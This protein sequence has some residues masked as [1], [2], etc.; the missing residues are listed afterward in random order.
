MS[1]TN[2]E[3]TPISKGTLIMIGAAIIFI[4][5]SIILFFSFFNAP[6]RNSQ[7]NSSNTESGVGS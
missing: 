5:I 2:I 3:K 6:G 1:E 7:P 4:V